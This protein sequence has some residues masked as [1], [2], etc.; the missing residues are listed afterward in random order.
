MRVLFLQGTPVPPRQLLL[1]HEV[2]TAYECGWSTV[3]N[4]ELLAEAEAH[5]FEV[6]VT[7]DKNL[8]YQQN[9]A[10][11]AIAVVVLGTTNWPRIKAAAETVV[12]GV[13]S[14]APGTYTEVAVP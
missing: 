3:K 8:K 1:G 11:R 13:H 2:S 14:A 5:G 6:L 4:G 10:S 7:T 9:L 12:A